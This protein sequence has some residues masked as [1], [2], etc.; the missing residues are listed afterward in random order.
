MAKETNETDLHAMRHSLAHIMAAAIAKLHPNAMFGVGPVV[1]DGFYYDIDFGA[2][3]ITPSDLPK[4]E[5][6]MKKLIQADLPFEKFE[7]PI[8]KAIAWAKTHRQGYKVELL[9]DLRKRGTTAVKDVEGSDLV[10]AKIDKVTFYR[11]GEF[12]DLCRGPHVKST[13]AV[14]AFKLSKIAGAY[15]R[16]S[17]K[18]PMLTRI[19]GA[20]F[21]AQSELDKYLELEAEAK[22][23]DHRKLGQEL[24]L[25][26]F[27][28]LVGAGLPLWT[29]RG[30]LLRRQLDNFVQSLREAYGYQEVTIPHITKKELYEKSGHWQKFANE[31]FKTESREGHLFAMK[32]MN[33]PHHAQI[34]ASRQR[35]YRDLPIRYRETTMVYRDEQSGELAGLSRVRSV[36][37]DDAHV[38]CRSEQI[39]AE[40]LKIWDI[41]ESFYGAFGFKLS[42]RFSRYDPAKK[43][44]YLGE[45]KAWLSTETQLK[46]IVEAKLKQDYIDG[47]GE[48]AF[49]GPKVDFMAEDALGRV[50]Q[51][52][53]IQ[54]DFNQPEG[55]DLACINEKGEPERIVMIHAAIMGSI[56][57]FLAV[58]IEHVNGAFPVWLAP[59]QVRL[60]TI[61]EKVEKFARELAAKMAAAGLRVEIDARNESI[62]KKIRAAETIKVPYTLVV[63][64]KEA[65]GGK[66]LPRV[67]KDIAV[68]HSE[69]GIEVEEFIKTVQNEAKS[70][71]HQSS[72]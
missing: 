10:G 57:R 44:D 17:E 47:L 70:R 50:W 7:L 66:L 51:V 72:L 25:F 32:P 55:F 64:E 24:D 48:A 52:A 1:E 33:C 63:G 53:T 41:V 62:G 15:W 54:V 20:A 69:D 13:G 45:E 4:I 5:A 8:D 60:V 56:E 9:S 71:V 40:V 22:H 21:A 16:G 58:Y 14:G 37:Q 46:K 35:S 12:E 18:N 2:Q 26:V 65:K 19:Y 11:T 59:E 49:Y 3:A 30:T 29:P 68:K 23:R 28:D 6:E 31:L 61:N 43:S 36:T 42:V 27:S 39:E 67:R 38:F 34:Y